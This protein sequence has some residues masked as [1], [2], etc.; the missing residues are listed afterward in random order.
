MSRASLLVDQAC[1]LGGLL[2]NEL[3]A[4]RLGGQYSRLVAAPDISPLLPTRSFYVALISTFEQR[5][6]RR[7]NIDGHCRAL[8]AFW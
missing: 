7:W 3:E 5:A 8:T 1:W 6:R 2:Q 4:D